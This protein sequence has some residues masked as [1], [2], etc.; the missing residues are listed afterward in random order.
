MKTKE[1]KRLHTIH[2]NYQKDS[3]EPVCKYYY[4]DEQPA[5]WPLEMHDGIRIS[6]ACKINSPSR[7]WRRL[8]AS[9][10]CQSK[11]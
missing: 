5:D 7:L 2:L 10:R 8:L 9:F 3:M 11:D 6:K 1:S 4:G